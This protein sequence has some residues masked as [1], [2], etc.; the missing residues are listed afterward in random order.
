MPKKLLFYVKIGWTSMG[1][2]FTE[3]GIVHLPLS[4]RLPALQC[5]IMTL[6]DTVLKA[7]DELS[8]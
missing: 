6:I 5:F 2:K 3:V 7:A 8:F 1:D 4:L